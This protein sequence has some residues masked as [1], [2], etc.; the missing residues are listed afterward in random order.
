MGPAG[1]PLAPTLAT[2]GPLT[3]SPSLPQVS[4]SPE[5]G[6]PKPQ[7][8]SRQSARPLHTL[9]ITLEV[10]LGGL[11]V[12]G[13]LG[14]TLSL[15]VTFLSAQL[16]LDQM[17][18]QSSS[19]QD[20]PAEWDRDPLSRESRRAME[21]LVEVSATKCRAELPSQPLAG[22]WLARSQK[23]TAVSFVLQGSW[24]GQGHGKVDGLLQLPRG[25]K[26]CWK[27]GLDGRLF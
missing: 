10:F 27:G 7:R 14:C 19:R 2:S 18:P 4:L 25:R 22:T 15:C 20:S 23:G 13:H 3:Q 8:P 12:S 16:G 11:P 17:G 5:L 6:P 21:G 24:E 1:P 26:D 9:E